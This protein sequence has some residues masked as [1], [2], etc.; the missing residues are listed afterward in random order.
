M[1]TRKDTAPTSI[2]ESKASDF[3][4]TSENRKRL[5]CSKNTGLFLI[6]LKNG[7]SWRYRYT[8][9]TG[10]RREV[11]LGAY[12]TY[13]PAEAAYLARQKD[14]KVREGGDPLADKEQQRQEKLRQEVNTVGAF[15]D[16][17]YTSLQ[18]RKKNSG[19]HTL[20]II[21]ANF[22][23]LLNTQMQAITKQDIHKWQ[24]EREKAGRKRAT[25]VRAYSAF[26]TMLRTA[27]KEG[28]IDLMPLENV[29]LLAK[30]SDENL[31]QNKTRRMLE[32]KE[33]QSLLNALDLYN[34][35][36]K[37]KRRNSREHGKPHLPDLDKKNFA[38]WFIPFCHCALHLGMRS[39]DLYTLE[40]T[41]INLKFKR[42]VKFAEKTRHHN[43]PTKLDLPLNETIHDILT[44]WHKDLGE[45]TTGLVF[46]SPVN[47]GVMDKVAHR[48]SWKNVKK[49]A[50][51][52]F[53]DNLV[54]YSL[55]HH[56]ISTLVA[57]GTPLLSVARLAGHKSTK[58]I[59][60]HYGHLAP[61]DAANAM[62]ALGRTFT[63]SEENP[64]QKASK[65]G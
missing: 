44:K 54:F 10:K 29:A 43:E 52:D 38:H 49:L 19:K 56:F 16:G 14:S 37:Q 53:D 64:K 1:A 60:E 7:C 39:G 59:E 13:M 22:D 47:N 65:H 62:E 42:L 4:K 2:T 55:R 58:M 15:L 35:E 36:L 8:D 28:Y 50:G 24:Q 25:I 17:Y 48:K 63:E 30:K 3:L 18:S 40:W 11:T 26:K 57:A 32:K 20:D 33:I 61:S 45:P 12:P 41:H 27:Q 34:E 51:E 5:G 21:R 46:K 6:K 9:L 31:D 23:F